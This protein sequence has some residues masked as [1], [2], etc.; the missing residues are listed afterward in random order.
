MPT[1]HDPQWPAPQVQDTHGAFAVPQ[2]PATPEPLAPAGPAPVAQG[3]PAAGFPATAPGA[4]LEDYTVSAEEINA[5]NAVPVSQDP[6]H[7]EHAR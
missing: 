1:G 4:A 2:A 3:T 6:M 5:A 7:E